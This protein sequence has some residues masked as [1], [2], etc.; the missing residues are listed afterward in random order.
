MVNFPTELQESI[1]NFCDA[2]TLVVCSR[3]CRLLYALARNC[4]LRRNLILKVDNTCVGSNII[5]ELAS[6]N[7]RITWRRIKRITLVFVDCTYDDEALFSGSYTKAARGLLDFLKNKLNPESLSIIVEHHWVELFRFDNFAEYLQT[8][9][10]NIS[11]LELRLQYEHLGHLH[12]FICSFRNLGT[13]ELSFRDLQSRDIDMSLSLPSTLHSLYLRL[14]TLHLLHRPGPFS[15][16]LG[17]Q[18]IKVNLTHLSILECSS[19]DAIAGTCLHLNSRLRSLYISMKDGSESGLNSQ[20]NI[21]HLSHLQDITFYFPTASSH[22]QHHF[23]EACR[24][25]YDCL[26]S[27]TSDTLLSV[28]IVIHPRLLTPPFPKLS[29]RLDKLLTQSSIFTKASLTIVTPTIDSGG[30]DTDYLLSL[31]KMAFPLF[32]EAGKNLQVQTTYRTTNSSW[33]P[34]EQS[35]IRRSRMYYRR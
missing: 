26:N 19:Y 22:I 1:L 5:K 18:F 9:F 14:P 32:T 20:F 3:V 11:R 34:F 24:T 7:S 23:R 10:P 25:I 16:W 4:L 2:E 17:S 31:A 15:H 13:L 21:S 12:R 35:P 6:P 27:I 29:P 30:H 28:A 33:N 8:T